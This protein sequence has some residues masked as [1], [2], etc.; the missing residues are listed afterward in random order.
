MSLEEENIKLRIQVDQLRSE[1]SNGQKTNETELKKS[2]MENER[3]PTD[4]SKLKNEKLRVD[5]EL[6]ESVGELEQ[7]GVSQEGKPLHYKG[8][9]IRYFYTNYILGGNLGTMTCNEARS[10]Y[11]D[12]KPVGKEFIKESLTLGNLFMFLLDPL[13]CNIYSF[14][15]FISTDQNPTEY[16]VPS[17]VVIGKVIQGIEVL[18]AIKIAFA[19][20]HN[21]HDL[22]MNE[23]VI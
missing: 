10:I 20:Q 11:G 4:N 1:I 8:T 18:H 21:Y 9:S 2:K 13:W 23:L 5:D 7:K 14:G 17:N 22:C 15:I 12:L 19:Y 6:K 16:S 3:L